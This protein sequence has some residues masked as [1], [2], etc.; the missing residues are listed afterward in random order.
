M[1]EL[2]WLVRTAVNRWIEDRAASMGAAIAYYTVFSLA[3]ILILVIAIAGLAFGRRAAEGALFGEIAGLV[4]QESAG[5]VQV[6][7]RS[8]SD[9][10]SGVIATLVS[11]A[12]LL[13]AATGVFGELQAALNLIWRSEP[14]KSM[15]VWNL[16]KVRLV[17]LSLIAAIGFLLLV[18][19]VVSAALTAFSDY[20]D[21]IL[22][23]LPA[24][25]R[26]LHLTTAFGFT[27]VFFAMVFKILP[28]AKVRWRDVWI[29][30]A[31]TS[32]LF[33]IGKYLISLYI[34]S[35]SVA[36]TYGAAGALV[37][38]LVWVYYSAQILLFGAEFTKVWHD[39]ET[40]RQAKRAMAP[41]ER[42]ASA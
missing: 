23:G 13:L 4:G 33:T 5:A 36:S 3:P 39:R 15:P 2:V 18:S 7:L 24:V 17:S 34:G 20:L 38:V 35:S 22:P 29:G 10:T 40:A 12:T 1:R 19:L 37:V 41:I 26:A 11:L 6:M 8:A 31:V 30:A 32:F 16:V 25:L 21:R 14:P 9:T 28:D 42:R 27:T